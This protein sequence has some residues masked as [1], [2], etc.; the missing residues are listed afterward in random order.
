MVLNY[1]LLRNTNQYYNKVLTHT[2]HN[3]HHK[4]L[5]TTNAEGN[6]KN[7]NVYLFIFALFLLL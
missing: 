7:V 6:V 5:Q 1:S 2:S 4:N 3:G